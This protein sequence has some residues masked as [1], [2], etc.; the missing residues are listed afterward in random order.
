MNA[1]HRYKL[2]PYLPLLLSVFSLSFSLTQ[3]TLTQASNSTLKTSTPR[4]CLPNTTPTTTAS[5]RRR[6][7]G[8]PF[9]LSSSF[10][11]DWLSFVRELFR[12]EFS[13]RLMTSQVFL[14]T[15][16]IGGA[17][18][19]SFKK[20]LDTLVLSRKSEW[21]YISL[22][23]AMCVHWFGFSLFYFKQ[24]LHYPLFLSLWVLNYQWKERLALIS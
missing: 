17:D 14:L 5:Y 20:G 12:K 10:S 7:Y 1:F 22:I 21:R 11:V 8:L 9:R 3:H 6:K 24:T 4:S 15:Q 16:G 18:M 13:M 23:L 19:T 2:G